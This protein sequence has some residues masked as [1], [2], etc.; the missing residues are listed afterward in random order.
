MNKQNLCTDIECEQ[1]VIGTMLSRSALVHDVQRIFTNETFTD[2]KLREIYHFIMEV[3]AD[4]DE[5]NIATVTSKMMADKRS[6]FTPSDIVEMANHVIL[7]EPRDYIERLHALEL[8]RSL[9]SIGTQFMSLAS[10][11]TIP[12]EEVMGKSRQLLDS[13]TEKGA[14]SIVTLTDSLQSVFQSIGNRAKGLSVV[15]TPTGFSALDR[16]GGLHPTDF[17]VVAADT[18]QGKTSL[19]LSITHNAVLA[20]YKVAYYSLEMPNEQLTARLLANDSGINAANVLYGNMCVYDMGK[21]EESRKRLD[22]KGLYFDDRHKSSI[23]E[24]IGSIR[25]MKLKYGISGAIVDYLQILNVN[26]NGA[27]REAFMGDCARRLKNLAMELD[28]W[29]IALSQ[30]S[31]DRMKPEP[32][33]DRLRDSGQ[34]AEAADSVFLIYR[35]E[36]YECKYPSPFAD[37]STHDTAMINVAKGRNTGV[38]KF[39]VGFNP[40]TTKFSNI[41]PNEVP[42]AKPCEDSNSE[43]P[44]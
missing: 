7:G 21:L 32:T 30:L 11:E 5:V 37:K 6:T 31:R 25:R 13:A 14:E 12:I 24:I 40:E 34:I 27:S 23:E 38:Q 20:D 33:L 41:E 4:G 1:L 36:Y 22:G 8:R 18:S 26:S 10:D 39:I 2:P 44:F 43:N 35:P 42:W 3:V 17:I 19:A 15:G 9:R 28:I 16:F 29:I